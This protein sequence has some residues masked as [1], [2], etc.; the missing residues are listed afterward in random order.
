MRA[1]GRSVY[2]GLSTVTVYYGLSTLNDKIPETDYYMYDES[3]TYSTSVFIIYFSS[4][5]A[6]FPHTDLPRTPLEMRVSPPSPPS[7][8]SSFTGAR[9]HC[10][11]GW[12]RSKATSPW[13]APPQLLS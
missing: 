2:Y 9:T 6:H 7:R 1:R 10:T 4:S 11:V 13:A 5:D 12:C 8:P 3:P